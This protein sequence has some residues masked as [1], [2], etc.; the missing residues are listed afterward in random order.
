MLQQGPSKVRL[1]RAIR[2]L[3]K[4]QRS[5]KQSF[6]EPGHD[7]KRGGTSAEEVDTP[8]CAHVSSDAVVL[9]FVIIEGTFGLGGDC[10]SS[11]PFQKG[12]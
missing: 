9:H 2:P 8:E 11:P 5:E 4:T 1:S 12:A 7:E 6:A 10:V 3:L